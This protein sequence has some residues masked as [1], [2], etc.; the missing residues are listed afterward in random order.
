MKLEKLQ[1]GILA[2]TVA[3]AT[4]ASATIINFDDLANGTIPSSYQGFSWSGWAAFDGLSYQTSYGNT[5]GGT[6][7]NKFG[8]NGGG[9]LIVTT[10]GGGL[11]NFNGADV[12]TWAQNNS[13]AGFSSHTLTVKGYN[14]VTL[15]GSVTVN[16]S[17][18]Q[19]LPL[20]ANFNG[21]NK[22]EFDNDGTDGHWWLLDNFTYNAAVPEPAT[23]MAGALLLIPIGLSTVRKLRKSRAA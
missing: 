10:T 17:T 2:L 6:S 5:Y 15:V 9:A 8:Y 14:G 19:F 18:T 20:V 22:L 16:L 21:I 1:I 12:S 7:A 23:V 4:S 13:F 3:G 11:F